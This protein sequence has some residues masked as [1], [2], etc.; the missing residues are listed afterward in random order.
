MIVRCSG[1]RLADTRRSSNEAARIEDL[2]HEGWPLRPGEEMFRFISIILLTAAPAWCQGGPATASDEEVGLWFQAAR[3]AHAEGDLPRATAEYEKV[4]RARP[5]I[6]EVYSNLGVVYYL[7]GRYPDASAQF[8]DALKRKP[9]LFVSLLFSGM[10]QVRMRQYEKAVPRL[11]QALSQ[12]PD[13]YEALYYL[14]VSHARSGRDRRANTYLEKLVELNPEDIEALNEL[15]RNYLQ[16]STASFKRQDRSA[17]GYLF[18]RTLAQLAES[19]GDTPQKIQRY[20]E[21]SLEA[22]PSYPSIRWELAQVLLRGNDSKGAAARL[23]RQ[24]ELEPN[25]VPALLTLAGIHDKLGEGGS[26][27][28]LVDQ[29]RTIARSIPTTDTGFSELLQSDPALAVS[30]LN[31]LLLLESGALEGS[32]SQLIRRQP[33]VGDLEKTLDAFWGIVQDRARNDWFQEVYFRCRMERGE[34]ELARDQLRGLRKRFPDWPMPYYLLGRVY[35]KL[36]FVT[37]RRMVELDPNGYRTHLLSAAVLGAQDRDDEAIEA[38]R[39]ALQAEPDVPGVHYQLGMALTRTMRLEEAV[40]E[41]QKELEVDPYHVLAQVRLGEIY[42]YRREHE[43]AIPGLRAALELDSNSAE[44]HG[45]LGRAYLL[46]RRVDEAAE[47]L[48]RSVKLD[49]D[50]KQTRYQL[51][52]A[53]RR[54]GRREEADREFA[55]FSRLGQEE[56]RGLG[57]PQREGLL[58]SD[59]PE[60]EEGVRDSP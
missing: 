6:A 31:V 19:Q 20:Y 34:L 15:G 41:F 5:E 12:Q 26:W 55:V 47:M 58:D 45:A 60:P 16:L 38:Y 36:S 3:E 46:A 18:F 1:R 4:L 37:Q 52:I 22:R 9:D 51:S 49:P 54:Q 24:V 57:L 40:A 39:A 29:A 14:G 11:E 42:V 56:K 50:D 44:A 43:K 35:E 25:H 2:S 13:S 28:Q 27:A 32:A 8:E 10:S 48:E 17:E 30:F 33:S 59:L 53:Y 7:R 23:S 21:R